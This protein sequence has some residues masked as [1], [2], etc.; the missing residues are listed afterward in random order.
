[1]FG[2]P[3]NNDKPG[4]L[5]NCT[6]TLPGVP[7]LVRLPKEVGGRVD[8]MLGKHYLK[9][10]PKEMAR[11]ESGLTLY[12][13][14]FVSTNKTRG[15]IAGPHPKFT[16]VH[17]VSNFAQAE[18][19]CYYTPSVKAYLDYMGKVGSVPLLGEKLGYVDA[20]LLESFHADYCMPKDMPSDDHA[21]PSFSNGGIECSFHLAFLLAE[22]RDLVRMDWHMWQKEVLEV[23]S[24]SK[25]SKILNDLAQRSRIDVW[26]VGIANNV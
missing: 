15:V 4:A 7:L 3:N 22:G 5:R 12:E 21:I 14:V 17:R 13:S 9:Y 23:L 25:R 16:M 1:M 8:L 24:V 19:H 18:S 20:E 6:P 26:N 2:A 11:L 10:F